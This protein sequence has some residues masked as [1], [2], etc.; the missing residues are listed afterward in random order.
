MKKKATRAKKPAKKKAKRKNT[1][2]ERAPTKRKPG[3]PSKYTPDRIKK[4]IDGIKKGNYKGVAARAAGVD[5]STLSEWENKYPEFSNQVKEAEASGETDLID[6]IKSAARR[7]WTAAAWLLERR[8]PDKWSRDRIVQHEEKP[9]EEFLLRTHISDDKYLVVRMDQ[10]ADKDQ[11][12]AIDIYHD[13]DF[14][15]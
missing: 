8:W 13:N 6:I 11:P 7:N 9:K 10:D 4:I 2:P 5:P 15:S 3:R 14:S 1:H 12:D